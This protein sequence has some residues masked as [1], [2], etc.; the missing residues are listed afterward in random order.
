M[1]RETG[2]DI[3]LEV[4]GGIDTQTAPLVTKAGADVL[5]AGT[6]IFRKP[7]IKKAVSELRAS[8]TGEKVAR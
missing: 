3:R 6:S 5:V 4:D 2:K 1:I 7:D 8:A